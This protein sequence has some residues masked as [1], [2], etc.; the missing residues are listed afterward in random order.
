M[1]RQHIEW[2][3]ISANDINHKE[4]ISKICKQFIQFNSKKQTNKQPALKM[5]RGTEQRCL[6][7]RHTNV[8]QAQ[9]KMHNIANHQRNA[10]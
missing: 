3:K 5:G 2:G 1:K 6:Q 4:L 9:E 7:R 10:N 8:Q